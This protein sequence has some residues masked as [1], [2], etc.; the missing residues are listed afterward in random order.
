MSAA[1]RRCAVPDL[2]GD[3]TRALTVVEE[4]FVALGMAS[5]FGQ[6]HLAL[7]VPLAGGVALGAA[8]RVAW[9]VAPTQ[10]GRTAVR[11]R[12]LA[13]D[14]RCPRTPVRFVEVAS[15][16]LDALGTAAV[17]LGR[18]LL[19]GSGCGELAIMLAEHARSRDTT[20]GGLVTE[21]ARLHGL[22]DLAWTEDVELL[23]ARIARDGTADVVVLTAAE[24]AAHQ[25]TAM[26][27]DVMWRAGA[28]SPE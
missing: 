14:G 28:L 10:S 24:E 27:F 12:L 17:A 25:R 23:H 8:V 11:P 9:A 21:L 19:P 15:A 6:L 26:R 1:R 4:L 22:L 3:L 5:K 20:A 16:D 18:S 7:P 13:S 2:G